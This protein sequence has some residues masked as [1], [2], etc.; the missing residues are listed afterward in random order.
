ME[1]GAARGREEEEQGIVFGKNAVAETL[2]SASRADTLYLS[3]EADERSL[4]YLAALAKER[5][6]VVKKLHPLK[7]QK[8][9]GSERHQGVALQCALCEY[10][11]VEDMLELA[12]ERGEEPFLLLLDGLE[13]P[14]NL[15]AVI[16]TAECAGAHGVIIPKRGGCSITPAVVRSAAGAATHMK[17]ARVSNLASQIRELKKLGI[18]FYC[19]EADGESCFEADLTGPAALVVGSEGQGVSRLSRELCDR[20]IALPLKG[21]IGSLNASVAAGVLMYE[22]VRQRALKA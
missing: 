6:A 2:K 1:K 17:I 18:F 13:D 10:C 7:L 14:H 20:T 15:G 5:G 4:A 11:E 3:T 16:R 8:L 12:A 21:R 9:C 22:I 19:A